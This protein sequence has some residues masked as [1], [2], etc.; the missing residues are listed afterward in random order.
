MGKT[1][2]TKQALLEF[3]FN[4]QIG[5]AEALFPMEKVLIKA[6]RGEKDLVLAVA[7]NNSG[8]VIVLICP[9]GIVIALGGVESMEDLAV[10]ERC[11]TDFE[12][13][14]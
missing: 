1:K 12:L 11:I 6:I 8:S 4:H 9:D 10:I 2:I 3:G 13:P 5:G 14:Y 7:Q